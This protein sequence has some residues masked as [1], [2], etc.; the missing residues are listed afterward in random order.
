MKKWLQRI[1]GAIGTA[2]TWAAGWSV[3][4]AIVGVVGAVFA[5]GGPGLLSGLLVTVGWFAG[6]S[7]GIQTGMLYHYA[8]AMIIG[9]LMLL[10]L[11]LF[12]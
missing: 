10:V 7:R 1:R 8:F 2:L 11:G 9:V 5:G 4:G 3:V 6:V 12:L